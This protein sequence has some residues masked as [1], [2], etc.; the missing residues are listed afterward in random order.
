MNAFDPF[1]D[2]L[3]RDIRNTLSETLSLHLASQDLGAIQAVTANKTSA[4]KDLTPV[5]HAYIEKRLNSY[6]RCL[7]IIRRDGITDRFQQAL[8]LWDENL[9]YEVHEVLESLWMQAQGAERMGLQAIIRAAGVYVHLAQG[10][11]TAARSMADKA[12]HGLTAHSH[13]LPTT[14]NCAALL[15]A[16]RRLDPRPPSLL[17]RNG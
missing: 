3:A 4:M 14:I 17:V 9:F 5:H 7:A 6:K 12:A 1:H 10:H 2:R 16:L 8:I 11:L 15:A 13:A